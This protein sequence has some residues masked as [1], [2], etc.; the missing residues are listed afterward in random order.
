MNG[1]SQYRCPHRSTAAAHVE[2]CHIVGVNLPPG[3][4]LIEQTLC[5]H[6]RLQQHCI[7]VVVPEQT[8]K[9]ADVLELQ[10]IVIG[11]GEFFAVQLGPPVDEHGHLPP[12]QIAAECTVV[13]NPPEIVR[14]DGLDRG[15]R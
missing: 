6:A 11:H 13:E 9:L 5:R 3:A 8:E 4:E 10:C 14:L 12:D 7:D 2:D 15:G 1:R